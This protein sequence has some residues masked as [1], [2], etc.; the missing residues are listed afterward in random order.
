MHTKHIQ[1]FL[2]IANAGSIRAAAERLPITQS[3]LTKQLRQMEEEL[4]LALFNRT[5]RGVAPTEFGQQ[6]LTRARAIDAEVKRFD[7]EVANLRGQRTGTLRVSVAPLAAV[8]ILPR[9]VARFRADFPDIDITISSDLF[10]EALRALREGHHDIIIGPYSEAPD[11][12][13]VES[14]E[15]FSTEVAVITAI[16]AP[17]ASATSLSELEN[18]CWMM[19]GSTTGE[20]RQR[21]QDQFT[22]HGFN[23]PNIRY[24]SESRLG[25]LSLIEEIGAVC[26]FPVR[27]LEGLGIADNICVVPVK[28]KLNPLKISMVTRAGKSLTPA[29]E[30]LADCIRH[31]TGVVVREWGKSTSPAP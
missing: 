27:L 25:L 13:D 2:A 23:A 24:A 29:G 5:S 16:D 3:A 6:L 31:R 7:Q 28:E 11:V 30:H 15:L 22:R 14:E 17:H 19:M 4:G 1:A 12:N 10:G 26:T 8:K 18:C 21:F 20:P 9:A